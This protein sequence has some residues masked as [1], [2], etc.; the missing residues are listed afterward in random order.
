M[1]AV[2]SDQ[3]P[4]PCVRPL[5]WDQNL[6]RISDPIEHKAGLLFDEVLGN[7]KRAVVGDISATAAEYR[8]DGNSNG[9]NGGNEKGGNGK[10]K[11][12]NGKR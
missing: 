2:A 10:G 3:A 5:R 6:R 8:D 12:G 7:T 9:G 11:G 4:A 1:L